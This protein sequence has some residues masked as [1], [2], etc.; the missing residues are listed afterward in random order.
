[1]N[2]DDEIDLKTGHILSLLPE[3]KYAYKILIEENIDISKYENNKENTSTASY[4]S[5]EKEK[6]LENN[7]CP[8]NT[9][10]DYCN[11]LLFPSSNLKG[12]EFALPI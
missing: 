7:T 5:T 1:M 8:G 2:K 11:T 10:Y 3:G 6:L 12:W 9:S 4:T